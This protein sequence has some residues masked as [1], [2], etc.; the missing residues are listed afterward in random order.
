MANV[1]IDDTK[2]TTLA[3]AIRSKTGKSDTMTVSE[4]ATEVEG[5]SGG[6]SLEYVTD[7]SGTTAVITGTEGGGGTDLFLARI[8]NAE[9]NEIIFEDVTSVDTQYLIAGWSN[10]KKISLPSLTRLSQA[11]TFGDNKNTNLEINIHNVTGGVSQ[12][13]QAL[14]CKAL[15][16]PKWS[17][18][19]N[20]YQCYGGTIPV[21]DLGISVDRLNANSL[22][23]CT[24]ALI[25][26]KT[27]GVVTL[28]N[29]NAFLQSIWRSDSGSGGTLYVPSTL[30]SSY[31]AATN[32]STILGYENNSIAAIEGSIYETRYAD[33]TEVT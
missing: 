2:L 25:L 14:K 27:D 24:V 5:I 3:N 29:V 11:F 1:L 17:G 28:D 16:L 18:T 13:L 32:W 4:M 22:T 26:R 10:L 9:V 19:L 20:T 8:S 23:S 21:I 6:A 30:I 15:V 7:A 31:E 12:G 33:G